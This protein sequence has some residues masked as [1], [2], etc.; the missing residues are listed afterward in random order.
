MGD[1]KGDETDALEH[2]YLDSKRQT[3]CSVHITTPWTTQST[4]LF[5]A[6]DEQTLGLAS[7]RVYGTTSGK[8]TL[9][10]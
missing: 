8:T 9:Y 1:G 6:L 5:C 2:I 10:L 7:R 3:Y 4:H